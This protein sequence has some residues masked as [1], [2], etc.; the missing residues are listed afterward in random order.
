M[1]VPQSEYVIIDRKGNEHFADGFALFTS[2]HVAIMRDNGMGGAI[3]VFIM[4]LDQV[5]YCELIEDDDEVFPDVL[6]EDDVD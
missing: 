2:Q 4:P 5:L 3:P 1:P 6:F